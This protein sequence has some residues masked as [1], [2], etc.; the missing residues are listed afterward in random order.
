MQVADAGPVLVVGPG[1]I[2][3]LVA[4]R[5][6]AAGTDV[7]VACRTAD[8]EADLRR[9]GVAAIDP[10]GHRIEARPTVVHSPSELKVQPRL[11]VLATK[12]AAAEG[13]LSSWLPR[14]GEDTPVVAMQNGVL[15]DRFLPL[16]GDRLVECTVALPATLESPGVSRQTAPGHFIVGPWPKPR[17]ADDPAAFKAVARILSDAA[18]VHA[19][20]NMLGVKWTKLLVNSCITSLGVATGT[21]LGVLLREATAQDAFLRIVEEGV[22]A[23]KAD[24]VSFEPVAGFRPGM[25]AAKVPGRRL[26]L[27]IV[28]RRYRR[29]KSS[30]LQSLERGQKTEVDYM[31]GH[32]V[33]T[34]HR[35]GLVAPVNEAMVNLL[36]RIEDGKTKPGIGN[37]RGIADTA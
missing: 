31:N 6:A 16:T 20:P 33:A 17:A 32:I 36:H 24:G 27:G 3:A 14:L 11:M 4:A 12:C 30:S 13:A 10:E 28:A 25:F 29:H 2:G 22:A 26:L 19:S 5:L 37:L 8:A 1:A 18:P 21:E 34:A 35:H 23:G 7:V 15:G 9:R